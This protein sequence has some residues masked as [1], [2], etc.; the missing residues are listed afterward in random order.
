MNA[1]GG[2]GM[3]RKKGTKTKKTSYVP[4]QKYFLEQKNRKYA[5][6]Y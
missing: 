2:R 4:N 3:L 5:Q 1:F 6:F